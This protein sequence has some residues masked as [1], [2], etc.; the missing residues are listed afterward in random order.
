MKKNK[1]TIKFDKK[2]VEI[3]RTKDSGK[4]G[5]HRNKTESCIIAIH[6]PTGLRAKSADRKQGQN[7]TIALKELEQRVINYENLNSNTQENN[8]RK[9]LIGSGQRGDKIRTYRTQDNIVIDHKN[10]N[11]LQLTDVLQGKIS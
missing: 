1:S 3:I 9:N 8:K 5:Q 2:D 6:K 10:N 4:G 11:K 7:L